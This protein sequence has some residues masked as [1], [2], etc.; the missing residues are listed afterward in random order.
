DQNVERQPEG[1]RHDLALKT[2]PRLELVEILERDAPLRDAE[3]HAGGM[4]RVEHAGQQRHLVRAESKPDPHAPAGA[5]LSDPASLL[6]ASPRLAPPAALPRR[7]TTPVR[8]GAS[9]S[10]SARAWHAP[11]NGM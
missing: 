3:L 7:G 6:H 9:F 2:L 10:K 5:W 4:H 11:G 1:E 8:A